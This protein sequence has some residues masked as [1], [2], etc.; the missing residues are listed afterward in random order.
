[1]AQKM[2]GH[3]KPRTKE[4]NHFHPFGIVSCRSPYLTAKDIE[5][6]NTTYMHTTTNI[7][8]Y[9]LLEELTQMQP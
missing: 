8:L 2:I 6:E 1:M 7:T 9:F 3:M 4:M 5:V